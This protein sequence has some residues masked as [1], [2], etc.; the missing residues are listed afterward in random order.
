VDEIPDGNAFEV[1]VTLNM[2]VPRQSFFTTEKGFMGTGPQKL[3]DGD[4]MWGLCGGSVP[5]ILRPLESTSHDLVGKGLGSLDDGIRYHQL[6]GD[7]FAHGIMDGEAI[8]FH[9]GGMTQAHLVQ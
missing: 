9:E 5:F 1:Y 6:F 3:K 8:Q 4:E 7:G 2:N